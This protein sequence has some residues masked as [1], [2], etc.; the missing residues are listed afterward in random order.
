MHDKNVL[1]KRRIIKITSRFVKQSWLQIEGQT[2]VFVGQPR[3]LT[4]EPPRL[5]RSDI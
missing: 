3:I 4:L 5:T 2:L 1:K